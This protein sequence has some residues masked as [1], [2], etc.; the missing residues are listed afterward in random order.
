MQLHHNKLSQGMIRKHFKLP[1]LVSF[2][3]ILV[4]PAYAGTW[5]PVKDVSLMVE[6]GSILDFSTLVPPAMPVNTRL[7]INNQGH[8]ALETQPDKN[9]RFLIGSL[10]FG[11]AGGGFPSHAVTDMY[12]QQFRLHGYNMARLDFVEAT[13]MEA[14]QKDFDFNPEQLD[15]FYYLM[16]ALKNN[17]IYYI[18]NGLSND[19]GGYGNVNERW[20]GKKGLH[21]GVYFDQESQAH[22]KQ[23]IN[24]MYGSVNPYTGLATI[25]DPAFAG[26]ILVNENNLTFV[27]RNGVKPVFKPYF[28]KW[29]KTKYGSNA[30][31]KSAWSNKTTG[32]SELKSDE[33]VDSNQINFPAA[34]AWTSL[35]MADTQAFFVDTEKKTADWMTQYVRKLGFSGQVSSYNLWHAPAAH[36]TRGQF[37]WVDMHNYFGH[38]D[39]VGTQLKV[40][41]DSMLENHAAYIREL[42]AARHLGKAFTL[43]EHGQVFW[44]RYRRESGLALPAYAALQNWGG[45]CQHSGAVI[46]SY[47]GNQANANRNRIN[48]FAVGQD[49]ISRATETLAALLYLRGDV[50]PALNTISVKL[51]PHDAFQ[52]SAHLGGTPAD[53][54]K[55]SLVTGV[56]LDWQPKSKLNINQNATAEI[57]FNQPGLR[58]NKAGFGKLIK[59][60]SN[61]GLKL[62]G[63]LKEYASGLAYKISKVKLLADD[64]W[65]ARVQNLR[66][67][68]L[69]NANNLTNPEAGIYQSDTSEILLDALQKRMVVITPKTEA[70]VFDEPAAIQL[71]QLS[72]M[73]AS[74]AALIAVSAM[75]GQE[76][77]NSKRMLIVLSTDARN[78]DMRFSDAS[79]TI[80]QD[81]GKLPVVIKAE[82]VKLAIKTPYK[83]QLKVFSTNLRGQ[84]QD[85]IA[86]KSTDY[87]IE[88]ELDISQLSHG[89]TTY[90]EVALATNNNQK[91]PS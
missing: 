45:I 19:N 53:V 75:D 14:R 49:P 16:A 76:L 90:F 57:D 29:L 79:E 62:D 15:R 10:G 89:A 54:S 11:V 42:S 26:M 59:P 39:Y 52:N 18:L 84:R 13:L 63:F 69:L 88:F 33:N 32:I 27:N 68:K 56:G 64:R 38:P 28:A 23:L 1:L 4:Q 3:F 72:V 2:L 20:I 73:S 58:L 82:K 12:V 61:L 60:T 17:G 35:R 36:A 7:I 31:L 25:K 51:T 30:A 6:E 47:A 8:W 65:A 55:L 24:K 50:A 86:A 43:S 40:R 48:P 67:A 22:W 41:Q 46:L 44:N 5:V 37:G 91:M 71:N 66:E 74:G 78:S 21:T 83:N 85:V 87:G 70:V 34:D 81:L 77:A 80:L 9:Q